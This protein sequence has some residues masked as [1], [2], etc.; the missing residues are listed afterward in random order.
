MAWR[1]SARQ[2]FS[3]SAL[4]V[5][6]RGRHSDPQSPAVRAPL[7]C[8]SACE[9]ATVRWMKAA[10]GHVGI[11][12]SSAEEPFAFW[13]DL[14][15]FL[16]FEVIPDGNHFDASDG[17]TSLCVQVTKAGHQV[18]GFHRKRT[19]LGHVAF[20]VESAELVDKFVAEFLLP[21]RIEPLYG[22][23]KAYPEY[24]PGYYAVYFEDPDR[25]KVEVVFEG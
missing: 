11:N 13:Q 15:V 8:S 19:G 10:L 17:H 14:L 21:R 24:T 22:G 5:V 3:A 18:P 20:K 12:L 1:F 25:I 7:A 6:I 2:Y 9:P 4:T 16:G 23:A